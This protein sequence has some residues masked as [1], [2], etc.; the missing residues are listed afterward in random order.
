MQ[1]W[2]QSLLLNSIITGNI[3]HHC[4]HWC[5]ASLSQARE[6]Q[7]LIKWTCWRLKNQNRWLCD[8]ASAATDH[9]IPDLFYVIFWSFPFFLPAEK[10]WK[11]P[12]SPL[13]S[14]NQSLQEKSRSRKK[15]NVTFSKAHLAVKLDFSSAV[16]LDIP[17]Q[18]STGKALEQRWKGKEEI[19]CEELWSQTCLNTGASRVCMLVQREGGGN[20]PMCGGGDLRARNK[21]RM[22]DKLQRWVGWQVLTLTDVKR[23]AVKDQRRQ[24]CHQRHLQSDAYDLLKNPEMQRKRFHHESGDGGRALL[25]A[26]DK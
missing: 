20:G 21:D 19:N 9:S 16:C 25:C 1:K 14:E 5:L 7:W 4:D 18:R 8:C 12:I 24:R 22:E 17:G 23:H 26:H 15:L 2:R 11:L 13:P 3:V 10:G 6:A